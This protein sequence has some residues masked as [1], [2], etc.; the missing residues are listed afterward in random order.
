MRAKGPEG[1][2]EEREEEEEERG[3]GCVRRRREG[4]TEPS[5]HDAPKRVPPCSA[6]T[7]WRGERQRAV[8]RGAVNHR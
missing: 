8:D 7:S 2:G 6:A 1:G 3:E 4:R 5:K